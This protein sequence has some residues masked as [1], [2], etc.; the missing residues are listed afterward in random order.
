[1]STPIQIPATARVFRR[2]LTKSIDEKITI[3]NQLLNEL[4]GVKEILQVVDDGCLITHDARINQWFSKLLKNISDTRIVTLLVAS[5]IRPRRDHIRRAEHIFALEVSELDRIERMGLLK[6]YAQFENLD[7][8][9]DDLRLFG[10]LLQGYPGQVFYTVNLIND[11]GLSKAKDDSYLVVEFN[12]EKVWK[13]MSEHESSE[14]VLDFL[15]LLADF[16]F[17]SYELIF[18]I[19]DQSDFY[20]KLL[21]KLLSYAIC[22]YLGTN[23]EYIRLNDTIRDYIKRN[24]LFLSDKYKNKLINHVRGFLED[25]EPEDYDISD[26]LYSVKRALLTGGEVPEKYLIPSHFLQ[27]N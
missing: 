17:I 12:S 8:T 7:L 24:R 22:E 16:D 10:G 15:R 14:Q 4:Q 27:G 18:E 3:A 21:D 5:S 6:R 25:Y 13:L 19:V 1:M 26:F 9:D 20:Q 23:R 11:I 2:L